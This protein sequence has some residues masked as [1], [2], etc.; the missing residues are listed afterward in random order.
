MESEMAAAQSHWNARYSEV[1]E[2]AAKIAANRA[3]EISAENLKSAQSQIN[4]RFTQLQSHADELQ[5]NASAALAQFREGI[6]QH[7]ERG[8]AATAEVAESAA[9]I[10]GFTQQFEAMEQTATQRIEQNAAN[11]LNNATQELHHRADAAELNADRG[12]VRKACQSEGG[13]LL[14]AQA[15]VVGI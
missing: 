1:A 2:E 9:R 11:V 6:E 12:E 10:S 7:A 3:S 14:G 15:Q 4:E 13:Q 5:A 8:R